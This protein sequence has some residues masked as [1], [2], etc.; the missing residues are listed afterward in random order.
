MKK[1]FVTIM[2]AQ[3]NY[4]DIDFEVVDFVDHAVL[5]VDAA[6]PRFF[7][8]EVAQVLHLPCACARM[9]LQ[10]KQQI[11]NLIKRLLVATL[12]DGGKLSLRLFRKKNYV[13][14]RLEGV[15]ERHHIL[16]ALQACKLRFWAVSTTNILLYGLHIATVGKELIARRA[17]LVRVGVMRWLAWPSSFAPWPI[18]RAR[19]LSAW[20]WFQKFACQPAA[21]TLRERQALD[22]G[23]KFV[24][25]NSCHNFKYLVSRCKNKDKN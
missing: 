19:W 16:L 17:Y 22:I 24:C 8:L 11:G 4:G 6:A 21:V 13:G 1:L 15:D 25:C 14:H 18:E 2:R 5:L 23:P 10:F 7:K 12:L 20:R 3:R 9:F